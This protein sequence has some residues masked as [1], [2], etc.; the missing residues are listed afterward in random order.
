MI[1]K[2]W[3]V[4]GGRCS[5]S[6]LPQWED[7][8][9]ILFFLSHDLRIE[10]TVYSSSLT[11]V[12]KIVPNCPSQPRAHTDA[13]RQMCIDG[14]KCLDDALRVGLFLKYPFSLSLL[15]FT[16]QRSFIW[17]NIIC[18]HCFFLTRQQL[19]ILMTVG[20]EDKHKKNK[21]TK[22][23]KMYGIS[24]RIYY[25]KNVMNVFQIVKM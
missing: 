15:L 16:V 8:F 18:K 23:G 19:P 13:F 9:L 24:L 5:I 1:E 10:F 3:I 17:N 7:D 4:V 25:E 6:P 21:I 20:R 11:F 22:C 2:P 12:H 14:D